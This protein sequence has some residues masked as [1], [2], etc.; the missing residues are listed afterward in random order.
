MRWSLV[1]LFLGAAC[2]SKPTQPAPTPATVA[3]VEKAAASAAKVTVQDP[4]KPQLQ[5]YSLVQAAPRRLQEID[6]GVVLNPAVQNCFIQAVVTKDGPAV[7]LSGKV[8]Y[9]GALE[10]LKI[11]GA[12]KPL[13]GCLKTA[14]KSIS[15]GRGRI[16][17][18]KM[19][20]STDQSKIPGSKGLI[21]TA[22]PV[23]KF[24]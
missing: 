6:A 12:D 24:E 20:L 3:P 8:S 18:F 7:S 23:K 11:T 4:E 21:L 15:L 5:L 10:S 13:E 2:Q 14:F 16:G 17:S 9:L 22:P 19:Q 1:L